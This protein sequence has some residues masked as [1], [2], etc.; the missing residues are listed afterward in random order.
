MGLKPESVE[1]IKLFTWIRTIPELASYCFSIANERT[2]TPQ[3]GFI[4]KRMGL[5]PGVSDIFIGVSRETF[6]GMFLELKAGTNKPTKQQLEFMER[7]ASQNYYTC[8]RTG[9]EAARKAIEEYLAL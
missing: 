5:M 7:M 4:L 6:H 2:T 9:Y 3:Q 1:Q 8:W